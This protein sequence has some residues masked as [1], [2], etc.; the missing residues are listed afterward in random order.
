MPEDYNINN[1][2]YNSANA[3]YSQK[4]SRYQ[5]ARRK[6]QAQLRRQIKKTKQHIKVL[7]FLCRLSLIIFLVMLIYFIVRLKYWHLSPRAFDSL[8]N[9]SIRIE[10][11]YIVPSERIL[12]AV[13]ENKVPDCPIFLM[14]TEEI[15]KSIME[16]S[17]IRDVYIKRF[18]LPAR[19]EVLVQEREPALTIAPNENVPPIAFYTKD[20]K[21]I[22]RAYM[23]L[24]PMF[25]TVKILTY[26]SYSSS[27]KFDEEKIKFLS[28]IARD[29]EQASKEPVQYID[30]RNPEDVYVQI[31][32]VK[33]K[34][35]SISAS[36]YP[37]TLKKINDLPS[38]LPKVKILN[39]KVKYIDLRWQNNLYYIKLAE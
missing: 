4:V 39:K 34:L 31:P 25:K 8:G 13:R 27:M 21:L 33:I 15:K 23:P 5:V 11:N 30:L 22:G 35:G 32:S 29:I 7:L 2:S 20:G 9:T 18:W 12:R 36:T 28:T 19:I 17:P 37:D 26:G 1:E 6:K 24:N 16:I 38:I 3:D 10:N 14:N